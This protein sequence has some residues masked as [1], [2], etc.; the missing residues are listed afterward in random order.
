MEVELFDCGMPDLLL[1]TVLMSVMA[2]VLPKG[3][4]KLIIEMTKATLLRKNPMPWREP[5]IKRRPVPHPVSAIIPY[6]VGI[7][8]LWSAH[9]RILIPVAS[10]TLPRKRE[11]NV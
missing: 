5:G 3:F 7:W 4:A 8:P 10:M 6:M 11:W 1:N 9:V 2:I